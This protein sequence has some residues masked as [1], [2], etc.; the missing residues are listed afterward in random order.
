[1]EEENFFVPVDG[2]TFGCVPERILKFSIH[3]ADTGFTI[4]N[5]MTASEDG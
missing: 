1:M 3:Y 5:F 2:R 4:E